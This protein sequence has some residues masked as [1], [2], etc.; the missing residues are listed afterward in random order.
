MQMSTA[1]GR[2]RGKVAA[3]P[4]ST[5]RETPPQ[6]DGSSPDD[7]E[8]NKDRSRDQMYNFMPGTGI[9][10]TVL[11][12]LLIQNTT[13]TLTRRYSV[14]NL[15]ERYDPQEVLLMGELFKLA[16]SVCMTLCDSQ[17]SDADVAGSGSSR[18]AALK[19]R[20]IFLTL[21]SGKML[22][23]ALIYA[24]MNALSFVAIRYVDAA[25]FTVCAQLKILTTAAFSV[26]LLRKRLSS[27]KW[28]ALTQLVLGI[29]VSL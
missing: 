8:R 18:I 29:F 17:A 20:L 4:L 1:S 6:L 25:V 21:R 26:A 14:A 19:A 5:D 2:M 11:L 23:L 10:T 12:L 28:R 7:L 3:D 15:A 9:K 24:I 16:F 27:T 22:A 13:Y